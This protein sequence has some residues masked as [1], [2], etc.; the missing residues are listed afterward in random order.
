VYQY[1]LGRDLSAYPTDFQSSRPKTDYFMEAQKSSLTPMKLFMSAIVHSD[2]E[3]DFD[4]A[5]I[6]QLYCAFHRE[7][8]YKK[9]FLHTQNGFSRDLKR[10]GGITPI[11]KGNQGVRVNINRK[12]LK[13]YLEREHEFDHEASLPLLSFE[14]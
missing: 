12:L 8:G 2:K 13:E 3:G 10:F 6:Y 4:S 11:P 7:N 1:L 5:K 9:D 14:R